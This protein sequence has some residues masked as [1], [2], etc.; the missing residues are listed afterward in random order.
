MAIQSGAFRGDFTLI[1]LSKLLQ[2]IGARLQSLY[3]VFFG[4]VFDFSFL[5]FVSDVLFE[6][7]V[8]LL[9]LSLGVSAGISL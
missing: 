6:Q 9:A 8:V 7:T 2:V 4:I 3:T 1:F 5:N